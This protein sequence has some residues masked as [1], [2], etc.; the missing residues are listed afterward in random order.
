MQ[1]LSD[2][3]EETE[4]LVTQA[5]TDARDALGRWVAGRVS[6]RDPKTGRFNG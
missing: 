6:Q 1:A 3:L 2:K 5:A 4:G